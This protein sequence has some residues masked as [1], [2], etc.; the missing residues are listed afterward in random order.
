MKMRYIAPILAFAVMLSALAGIAGCR[1]SGTG[2]KTGVAGATDLMDGIAPG[3]VTTNVD[4]SDHSTEVIDFAVR[5]FQNTA[6]MEKN[7][8]ISPFSVLYALAMTANGADGDTLAQMEEVFGIS[9]GDLNEYL[10]I[11]RKNLPSDD[12]NK[13]SL[14]NSIWFRDDETFEAYDDFLRLN[15]DYYGASIYKAPFDNETLKAIN[16]WVKEQTDGM[17]EDILDEIPPLTVMYLINAMAFDAEWQEVYKERQVRP[18]V[19]NALSG[20]KRDVEMMYCSVYSYLDDGNAT[21]FIKRYSGGRYAFA[22]L[23]PNEGVHINEYI[24]TLKGENLAGILQNVQSVKV[25]TAIPKFESEFSIEMSEILAGMGMPDAFDMDLA[26]L[27]KLGYSSI[28]RLY[29]N[30]VIHKTYIS[31]DEQGTKAGASTVVEVMASSAPPPEEPKTVYL[32]RPFV[33]M[34][35]DVETGIPFFIGTV[36]DL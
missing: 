18:G 16:K 25:D 14:V 21:G 2:A 29:I 1:A 24:S 22:A 34:I 9:V 19:F 32:D 11:Y 8:M 12:K 31:V 26:N 17:I 27:T 35:Y 28:G 10:Y 20:A 30:R 7:S 36:L 33:Y 6:S 23:L 3:N 5:L 15:A 13:F 4:L